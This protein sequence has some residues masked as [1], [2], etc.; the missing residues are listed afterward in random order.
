MATAP[1]PGDAAASAAMAELTALQQLALRMRRE[2]P[3]LRERTVHLQTFRWTFH[4]HQAVAYLVSAGV[5]AD[6]DAAVGLCQ[7]LLCHSFVKSV[8]STHRDAF[9][10]DGE[11]YRFSSAMLDNTRGH[12]GLTGLTSTPFYKEIAKL[13]KAAA[14]PFKQ[15]QVSLNESLATLG[16]LSAPRVA[17][18]GAAGNG[19]LGAGGGGGAAGTP[20]GISRLGRLPSR[21]RSVNGRGGALEQLGG[22]GLL[23]ALADAPG[24]RVAAVI[25]ELQALQAEVKE[26]TG[27]MR[28]DLQQHTALQEHMVGLLVAQQAHQHAMLV[29]AAAIAASAALLLAAVAPPGAWALQAAGAALLLVVAAV[30]APRRLHLAPH[31]VAARLLRH[32]GLGGAIAAA[33]EHKAGRQLARQSRGLPALSTVS[34]DGSVAAQPGSAVASDASSVAGELGRPEPGGELGGA[35]DDDDDWEEWAGPA[36]EDFDDWP[37]APVM[38]V[39]EPATRQSF[40]GPAPG[41]CGALAVNA[42]AIPFE[43]EL[44]SGALAVY[45]RHLPTTPPHLFKGK[46]RLVWI[47]LQVGGGAG[48]AAVAAAGPA[49]GARGARASAAAARAPRRAQGTF[50]RPISMDALVCGQDFGRKLANLPA[51]WLIDNML[52]PLARKISPALR[53]GSV[54]RPY[55]HS[56]LITASQVVNVALPGAAPPLMEAREDV[57]LVVEALAGRPGELGS[58]AARRK[59][60]QSAG[61][62]ARAVFE[63]GLVWT[64]HLWQEYIDYAHYLLSLGYSSYD[65][66]QHLDGQPLQVM[67]KDLATGVHLLNLQVWHSNLVRSSQRN[68][69]SHTRGRA[70]DRS[71]Q[72]TT[73]GG[74]GAEQEPERGSPRAAR[75]LSEGGAAATPPAL[76]RQATAGPHLTRASSDSQ[77]GTLFG[78]R[79]SLSESFPSRPGA[80]GQLARLGGAGGSGGAPGSPAASDQWFDPGGHVQAAQGEGHPPLQQPQQ[81]PGPPEAPQQRQPPSLA[82]RRRQGQV[83]V[84]DPA[85]SFAAASSGSSG[86]GASGGSPTGG[87]GARTPAPQAASAAASAG[88]SVATS[89]AAS[90]AA[91]PALGSPLAAMRSGLRSA[92]ALP[93]LAG[94]ASGRSTPAAAATH[95]Y[96]TTRTLTEDELTGMGVGTGGPSAGSSVAT[97]PSVA[98]AAAAAARALNSVRS[99]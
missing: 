34:A 85:L 36:L 99:L 2:M 55:F 70:R 65:L 48:S 58:V 17:A 79:R 76:A 52:L 45:V 54:E 56:P 96:T 14:Q 69:R 35:G 30:A 83:Q 44:F 8:G 9:T 68:G 6:A 53:V 28:L 47:A 24:D 3:G 23:H 82:Q 72:V 95:S 77:D 29:L 31:G 13:S 16:S 27:L 50:K 7:R 12:K 78:G 74:V 38:L 33:S 43:S 1:P 63:P 21:R 18:A 73:C 60:F 4:G 37:D 41:P 98:A 81:A 67:L 32:A 51:P 10:N 57:S 94:P 25:A 61:A 88:P 46:K 64:F 66:T 97:S 26:S 93:A 5:A 39:P 86:D 40:G 92:D 71:T 15:V 87:S 80:G 59:L 75:R 22:A 91:S 11:L 62:R 84:Q 49:R 89:A 20:L 90:G 19:G 42:G